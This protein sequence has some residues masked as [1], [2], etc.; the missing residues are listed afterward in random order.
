MKMS[1]KWILVAAL[2]LSVAMAS[3]GTIAYL[4]DSDSDVN[5]MTMGSVHIKQHE[6]E[7]VVE[8]GKYKTAD[9]DGQ[10]SY[11]LKDFTQGKP[12]V[13][14][15]GDPSL[16]GD[17]L[18]YA[19]WDDTTV[20]MS[21]VDSYGG[22][23]VFAGKN[24][25]DK[26]VTVENTG[27]SPAYVRTLVAI[28]VGEGDASLIGSSYHG[29]WTEKEIG[30]IVIDGNNY[31][32]TEY[33]YNGAA[34]VRH[35]NGILP[36]GD[37]TYPNLSQVYLKSKTTN[38]DLEAIDGNGDGLLDILVVSQAVQ[39]DGFADAKTALDT[40]FGVIT[41]ESH[42]WMAED[43]DGAQPP[44]ESEIQRPVFVTSVEELQKALDDAK[45]GDTIQMDSD[46][47]GDLTVTQKP[48][49]KITLDGNGH[50]LSGVLTVDGKSGTYTTAGLTVKNVNFKADSISADA[51][52]Q[53]GDGTS[54]TRYTCNVTVEDCTFDVPG[55]VGIKSYTGG[56]KNLKVINCTA[57][58]NAHSLIQA[59][60]ID[61]ILVEN[62]TV[63]SKNGLN[64]NNSDNVKVIG[65][66]VDVKG[67]AVRFG[68][69]S[70]G[71]GAAETY[72]IKDCTLKSANEDGDA[73]IILRGTADNST[74]TI[75]NT[76]IE[77]SPD[78]KNNAAGATVIR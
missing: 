73:T 41:V 47:T 38:E 60:G 67:Y 55:A 9:I 57:T 50:K 27:K 24:A 53:L 21:Q 23:Q 61:G 14:I 16:P 51:C 19:G 18:G 12:I 22:M 40:A 42:P 78:I 36:A 31:A 6:Y 32:L 13:P 45:D 7:R 62:C 2:V 46:I 8:D 70:G 43:E 17:N 74:L 34:G 26:F 72:L 76:T 69:S 56:D 15:V 59:K 28:E 64:F 25:Q 11:V 35:E 48:N 68:E 58:E 20:R 3:S 37:T 65:C 39:A 66:N 71:V 30:T 49:V 10:T 33:L 4:Q 77:G 29:T 54:A 5:V 75:M 1:R 52:I 63:K 44:Y